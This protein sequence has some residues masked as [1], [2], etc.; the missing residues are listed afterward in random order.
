VFGSSD[1]LT[2]VCRNGTAAGSPDLLLN[3]LRELN[4]PSGPLFAWVAAESRVA[5]AV[6]QY[7]ITERSMDKHWV[8]AAGYWRRGAV[9]AHE[10]IDE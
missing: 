7:L 8:K 6:R 4:W 3:A 9:G 10:R 1:E 2:W 5:R